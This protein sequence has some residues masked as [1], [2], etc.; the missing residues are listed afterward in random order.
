MSTIV[1]AYTPDDFGR[2]ALDH[3]VKEATIRGLGLVLVNGSKGE[4]LVDDRFAAG[5]H[6]RTVEADLASAGLTVEVRQSV[7]PDVANLVL[8]VA[9]ETGAELIVVGLRNRTPVGKLLL[10]S[11]AQRILLDAPMPVLAVRPRK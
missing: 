11:V 7:G 1:V 10:G 4:S 3:A 2:A 5:E 8:D 9:E 6:L